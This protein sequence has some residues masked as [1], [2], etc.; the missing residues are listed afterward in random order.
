MRWLLLRNTT[1]ILTGLAVLCCG[2]AFTQAVD[3]DDGPVVNLVDG[4]VHV[5]IQFDLP[6]GMGP[7]QDQ[8]DLLATGL[9]FYTANYLS[10]GAVQLPFN[11]VGRTPR[12]APTAPP[13]RPCWC[14]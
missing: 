8:A 9:A 2:P 10:L 4:Q 12:W 3:P 6:I 1:R 11:I 14:P 5:A 13:Y 7:A